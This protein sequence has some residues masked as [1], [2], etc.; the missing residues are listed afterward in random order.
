MVAVGTEVLRR[1]VNAH[2]GAPTKVALDLSAH[3]GAGHATVAS[4][5]ASLRRDELARAR[6]AVAEHPLVKQAIA[7]FGAEL[8]DVRLPGRDD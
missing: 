7:L 4:I 5:D 8:R 2:F 6:L 1:E 3:H